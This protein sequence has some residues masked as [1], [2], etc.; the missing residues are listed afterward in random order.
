MRSRLFARLLRRLLSARR[1]KFLQTVTLAMAAALLLLWQH[2]AALPLPS[3]DEVSS[4]HTH[5]NNDARVCRPWWC[6]PSAPPPTTQV[7]MQP[8]SPLFI[9]YEHGVS[10]YD[11][12]VAVGG[13]A[14][15]PLHAPQPSQHHSEHTTRVLIVAPD[16]A[17]SQQCLVTVMGM[18]NVSNQLSCFNTV[19]AYS[20]LQDLPILPSQPPWQLDIW[21]GLDFLSPSRMA[22]SC[23]Q[24]PPPAVAFL[25]HII[26]HYTVLST[27][28]ALLPSYS[29]HGNGEGTTNLSTQSS[30]GEGWVSDHLQS[31]IRWRWNRTRPDDMPYMPLHFNRYTC[32]QTSDQQ[33]HDL[34]HHFW[35]KTSQ[36]PP[37]PLPLA[38]CYW[39]GSSFV[40]HRDVILRRSL[41]FWIDFLA[42]ICSHSTEWTSSEAMEEV[43]ELLWHVLFDQAAVMRYEPESAFIH[44]AMEYEFTG[45]ERTPFR[46][47]ASTTSPITTDEFNIPDKY[48]RQPLPWYANRHTTRHYGLTMNASSEVHVNDTDVHHDTAHVNHSVVVVVAA[49]DEDISFVNHIHLPVIAYRMRH[50]PV[51]NYPIVQP[52]RYKRDLFQR[53]DLNLSTSTRIHESRGHCN[54]AS[55]YLLFLVQYYDSLPDYL[56]FIHGHRCSWHSP[57][58]VPVLNHLNWTYVNQYQQQQRGQTN[59]SQPFYFNFY[60]STDLFDSETWAITAS[61]W[62]AIFKG[63]I[64]G[65]EHA[66]PYPMTYHCCG[67]FMVHKSAVLA[68]TREFWKHQYLWCRHTTLLPFYAGRIFEY[69]WALLMSQPSLHSKQLQHYCHTTS[70]YEQCKESNESIPISRYSPFARQLKQAMQEYQIEQQRSQLDTNSLPRPVRGSDGCPLPNGW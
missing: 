70:E 30:G 33:H 38:L 63:Q 6:P 26:Q 31:L 10:D 66:P 4:T 20:W 41:S 14:R 49:Y 18:S 52:S 59:S 13:S 17:Y 12:C 16:R 65:H 60:T 11:Q 69:S 39:R 61:Y 19:A 47:W 32:T 62:Q 22:I 58:I 54:E 44:S 1:M 56:I 51:A 43:L 25:S 29:Q 5:D 21:T 9:E 24:H 64:K 68:H 46:R 53:T 40:V 67:Q 2:A 23:G 42:D 45:E 50:P 15:H 8:L 34:L 37:R 35:R 28:I 7:S 55:S 27:V 48:V 57:D 3:F 36:Q